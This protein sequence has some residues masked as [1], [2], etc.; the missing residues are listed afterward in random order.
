MVIAIT[1]TY[2]II[3][4]SLSTCIQQKEASNNIKGGAG[5]DL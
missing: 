3:I 1:I 2:G 4:K 5:N